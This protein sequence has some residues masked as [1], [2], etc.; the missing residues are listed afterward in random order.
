M[1]FKTTITYPN[2]QPVSQEDADAIL[3]NIATYTAE[4]KYTGEGRFYYLPD[5]TTY[6]VERQTW[7]D[8]AACQEYFNMALTYCPA[9]RV[10]DVTTSVT[11]L[12]N[13][14]PGG[15]STP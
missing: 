8:E 13:A 11:D 14:T 12:A 15:Q 6:V 3:A 9:E 7:I 10:V 5:G 4:G 2:Y 1:G